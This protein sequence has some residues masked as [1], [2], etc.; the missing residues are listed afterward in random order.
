MTVAIAIIIAVPLI[1]AIVLKTGP[2]FK[3]V[4]K[5]FP[6][7]V[8]FVIG[9]FIEVTTYAPLLGTSGTYLAFF[10]G[11]LLNL[12]VPC[13]VNA[14]EQAGVVHGSKE[15]EIVD[16][17]T[18]IDVLEKSG[19]WYSY[20]GEKIGQGKE[21]VKALLKENKDLCN[22]LEYKIREHYDILGDMKKPKASKK[23]TKVDDVEIDP[24]TGEVIE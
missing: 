22:E 24:E 4:L 17:A 21:N 9:G 1:M 2:D 5:S 10:T 12:K 18:E 14:R 15:G 13:A 7:L 3:V 16:L 20:N 19:A 23:T 6:A 8:T 11:N